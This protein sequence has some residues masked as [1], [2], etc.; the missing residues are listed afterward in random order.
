MHLLEHTLADVAVVS[1]G[2]VA[3]ITILDIVARLGGDNI[4][5]VSTLTAIHYVP[6][7]L[8]A[9][10]GSVRNEFS[11][12][13]APR[14]QHQGKYDDGSSPKLEYRFLCLIHT[15]IP[16]IRRFRAQRYIKK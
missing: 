1:V 15:V 7:R 2:K 8:V 3:C 12:L 6:L 11:S 4:K 13:L 10:D 14:H 9:I 5:E 16:T